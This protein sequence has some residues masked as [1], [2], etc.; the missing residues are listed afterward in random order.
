[1]MSGSACSVGCLSDCAGEEYTT[2][3]SAVE[4]DPARE[5][6]DRRLLGYFSRLLADPVDR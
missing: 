5:C 4:V 6:Q 1:M 2:K 3:Q